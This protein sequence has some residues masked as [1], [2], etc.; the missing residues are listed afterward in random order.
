MRKIRVIHNLPRS[1]GTIISKCIGAQK[2]VF[3]LSEIH[4]DGEKIR[5]MMGA[6]PSIGNPVIQALEWENFFNDNE[7]EKIKNLDYNFEKK[8]ELIYEKA[9][10][11][12]KKLVIRDWSFIDYLGLPFVNPTYKNLLLENLN[13]KFEVINFYI[14]RHPLE[15]F[16]SLNSLKLFE[17]KFPFE[18]FLN[19]YSKFLHQAKKNS[20]YTYENFTLEPDNYLKSMC[21]DIDIEFEENYLQNLKNI[22][23]TGDEKANNSSNVII[24]ENKANKLIEK[25]VLENIKNNKIY[26]NLIKELEDYY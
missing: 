15:L 7:K 25:E 21:D 10:S 20:I 8:I 3:V 11:I 23:I 26:V 14:L 5:R 16:I 22:K 19:G 1:G 17:N 2:N 4:P 9:E 12:G 24:N 6:K 18:F 13:K